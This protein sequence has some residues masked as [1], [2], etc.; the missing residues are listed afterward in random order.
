MRRATMLGRR[1]LVL[2][3][4]CCR[5]TPTTR[6]G[7]WSRIAPESGRSPKRGPGSAQRHAHCDRR[8][9]GDPCTFNI[10]FHFYFFVLFWVLGAIPVA[11]QDVG[12]GRRFGWPHSARS[13]K[14]RFRLA[15]HSNL[16]AVGTSSCLSGRS[17]GGNGVKKSAVEHWFA[18]ES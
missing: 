9:N 2:A 11:I 6:W 18:K 17:R 3:V 15:F 1:R 5:S 4:R 7:R 16:F 8:D 10:W 13:G 14:L 12:I